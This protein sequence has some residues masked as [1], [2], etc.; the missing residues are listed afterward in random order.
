MSERIILKIIVDGPFFGSGKT[1][2]IRTI[3]EIEIFPI[4]TRVSSNPDADYMAMDFGLL[5]AQPNIYLYL[6]GR[7][8][9]RRFTFGWEIAQQNLIGY[10]VMVDSTM[11]E[12][13]REARSLCAPLEAYNIAPYVVVAN[14]QDLP[15]AASPEYLR[16]RL[17][18]DDK[19]PVLPCVATDR[20]SVKAVLVTL[21]DEVIK[22]VEAKELE[23][24]EADIEEVN[25]GN[26]THDIQ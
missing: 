15:N 11:Q 4:H 2:F 1:T 18:V 16:E 23:E 5:R 19:I 6:L 3:S 21:L 13:W 26:N 20:E 12:T 10:I 14:K 24:L 22:A 8:G 9:S 7:S 25:E 17:H